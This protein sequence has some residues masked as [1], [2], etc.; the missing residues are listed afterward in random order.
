MFRPKRQSREI[1]ISK[2]GSGRAEDNQEI[3]GWNN[4]KFPYL[5][6]GKANK[7]K[8]IH[9]PIE[10]HFLLPAMKSER[11][12]SSPSISSMMSVLKRIGRNTSL[13]MTLEGAH[14]PNDEEVVNKF[15]EVLFLEGHLLGKRNDY[16]TLLRFLRMRDFDIPKAK[17]MFV[18]YIKWR[19]EYRVDAIAKE[20]KFEEVGE[21]KN[22]YPHGFHGVDRV[23]RPV[24]IE[25][26]GMVNM[27]ALLEVTKMERL[28]KY[29]VCEQE[30]TMI[31]RYPACSIIAKTHIASTTSILDVKGVGMS[32]FSKPAR[33]LFMEIQKIDSNYYP[34]TLHRLYIVN[35]GSGFRMLWKVLKPFLDVLGDSY[36]SELLETVDPSNLPSFLGGSCSCSGHGGCLFSDK[37]PWN[38]PEIQ[39][40]LQVLAVTEEGYDDADNTSLASEDGLATPG[41]GQ[42]DQRRQEEVVKKLENIQALEAALLEANTK[43]E[44]LETALED[45]KKVV[46]GLSQHIHQTLNFCID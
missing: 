34:E 24:Y 14:D 37:G 42:I 27:D 2:G 8:I 29:H 11:R 31:L 19:E 26:L 39:D 44:A 5:I 6:K 17:D 38:N 3:S 23:G 25:R 7:K 13:K 1:V 10:S 21:V 28:V 36:K 45:T 30:K 43:L 41:S 33:Y 32:S 40:L 35:A 9:P 16:H 18:N 46:K 15:R 12:S 22:C 4:C 20:F